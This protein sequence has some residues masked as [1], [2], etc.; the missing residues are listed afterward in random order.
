VQPEPPTG[1]WHHDYERGRP[2][3]PVDVVSVGGIPPSAA[4]AELGAGTGK[5]T[6]LLVERL[7]Q[8]V[9]FEPADGATGST[10][11]VPSSVSF[12]RWG[13]PS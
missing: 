7:D 5:L 3:W 12:A 11:R 2:G 9:A 10:A 13:S 1:H 6:R 8:V 4:V